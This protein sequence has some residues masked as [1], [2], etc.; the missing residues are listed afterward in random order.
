MTCTSSPSTVSGTGLKFP[1]LNFKFKWMALSALITIICVAAGI[2]ITHLLTEQERRRFRPSPLKEEARLMY[3]MTRSG[4]FTLDEAHLY[5][6]DSHLGPPGHRTKLVPASQAEKYEERVRINDELFLVTTSNRRRPRGPPPEAL[7]V[8]AISVVTSIIFGVALSF[9]LLNLYLNRKEREAERVIDRLMSGDLKARFGI[10]DH[11]LTVRFNEMA[12]RIEALVTDLRTVE[13]SRKKL[14]QELAHDLRTPVASLKNLQE[15]LIEKG[16]LM[17]EEKKLHSQELSLKEISYFERLVEDL[18]FLSGVNDP[19]YSAQFNDVSLNELIEEEIELFED[20]VIGFRFEAES[21]FSV[22]GDQHLLKRLLRNAI[23]NA[24]RFAKK[25]IIISLLEQGEWIQL[26][27]NDDG[28]GLA[29]TEL[30]TFGE[31]KFSRQLHGGASSQI[32]IG[33]GS[34]I[35]KKII[36]LHEGE[37]Q[38]QNTRPGFRL[39]FKF[40][41]NS[42][43]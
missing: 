2:F 40:P 31:K 9:I 8:G 29:E 11:P 7:V 34:V 14:L 39:S 15:T 33:L 32:S 37:M 10:G 38:S 36:S 21:N 6:Q 22:R 24:R 4:D 30:E 16:H 19:R 17:S 23:S 1:K 5:I 12:E 43:D 35:M 18:L 41:H 13:A 20:G 28:P 42:A 3:H 27:I 26:S 25:E